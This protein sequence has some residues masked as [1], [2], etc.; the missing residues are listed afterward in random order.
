MS[1]F[2][3]AF[4]NIIRLFMYFFHSHYDYIY[5]SNLIQFIFFKHLIHSF[6]GL[7]IFISLV[8]THIH[9]IFCG[10]NNIHHGLLYWK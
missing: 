5:N 1:Y 8:F 4:I 10:E 6:L 9:T 3:Y 7:G 2:E